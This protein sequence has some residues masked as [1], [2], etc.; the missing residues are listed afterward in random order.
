MP[1]PTLF[2]CYAAN[3]ATGMK[4]AVA[5]KAARSDF[6]RGY[7]WTPAAK[8]GHGDVLRFRDAA[9]ERRT[10][11]VAIVRDDD[12]SAPWEERGDGL[13]SDWTRRD[14]MPGELVLASD[15][16]FKRFYDF[17]EACR[18]ALREGWNAEPYYIPGETKRQRAAKAARADFERSRRWCNDDWHWVGVC[19]FE[20]PRDGVERH[21]QYIADAAP[22]GIL[23]HAALWGIESDS[24]AYHAEV[25]RDLIS[26]L[27]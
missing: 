5:V 20:L 6:A 1:N 13:V 7:R 2:Q 18:I 3:R 19:L 24:P 15:R 9:G 10:A 8:P 4:A 16:G 17:A 23:N 14:K 22:F 11:V 21:A 27:R 12:M 26:E 25:A